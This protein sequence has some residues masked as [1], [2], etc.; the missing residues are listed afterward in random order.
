M[1]LESVAPNPRGRRERDALQLRGIGT[2][3]TKSHGHFLN[4]VLEDRNDMRVLSLERINEEK[5]PQKCVEATQNLTARNDTSDVLHRPN[6][7]CNRANIQ[8][9]EAGVQFPQDCV[10][11]FVRHFQ[12]VNLKAGQF[13][14]NIV[15][16]LEKRNKLWRQ[17]MTVNSAN[18]RFIEAVELNNCLDDRLQFLETAAQRKKLRQYCLIVKCERRFPFLMQQFVLKLDV[19]SREERELC[20]GLFEVLK[21]LSRIARDKRS[22]L[23]NRSS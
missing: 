3:F 8:I 15:E 18:L 13:P 9:Q 6:R 12:K 16:L 7:S 1:L 17:N 21:R 22:G 2:T 23:L 10:E 20:L 19:R 4:V 11:L 14:L 5:P